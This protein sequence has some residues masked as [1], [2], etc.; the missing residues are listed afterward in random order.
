MSALHDIYWDA[1]AF[2]VAEGRCFQRVEALT[3]SGAIDSSASAP[4]KAI[5]VKLRGRGCEVTFD[6]SLTL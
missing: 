4:I 1:L 6:T 5:D 2:N 3:E